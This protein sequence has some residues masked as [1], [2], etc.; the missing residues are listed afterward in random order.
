VE[1]GGIFAGPLVA[2]AFDG[3]DVEEGGAVDVFEVVE[4]GDEGGEVVT[5]DGAE[6]FEAHVFEDVAGGEGIFD[7][8]FD[9]VGDVTDLLA[10]GDGIEE[11]LDAF[12]DFFVGVGDAEVFEVIGEGALG[13]GDAH[14]VVVEDDE[15]LAVEGAG[16]VEAFEG[17]AVDDGGIADEGD[18]ARVSVEEFIGAG[19]ADGGGDGGAGVTDGEE[20]IGRFFGVREAADAAFFAEGV[21]VFVATGQQL[22]GVALVSHI[23]EEAVCG[24]VKDDIHGEDDFDGAEVRCEVSAIGADGGHDGFADFLGDFGEGFEGEFAEVRGGMDRFKES[25]H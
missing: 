23:P 17:E 13:F 8:G 1:G 19:H 12:A 4:L 22:V 21:E 7:A 18:D 25:W 6:V 24:E 20:V 11:V 14:G 10:I 16:V 9:A 15:H 2:F 3:F 5:V